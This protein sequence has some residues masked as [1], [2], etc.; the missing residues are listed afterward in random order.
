[1]QKDDVGIR[2]IIINVH[3]LKMHI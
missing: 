1:M 2:L 3:V